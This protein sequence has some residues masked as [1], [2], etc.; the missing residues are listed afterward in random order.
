MKQFL[1][2][3]SNLCLTGLILLTCLIL[4]RGFFGEYVLA[5]V[6][7][8]YD[9]F[10][11]YVPAYQFFARMLKEG[12]S[13]YN[14]SYG[15]GNNVFI[16]ISWIADPFSA[17][18]VIFG[19]L[20]G[21]EKIPQFLV[22]NQ[23]LKILCAG[24]ICKHYLKSHGISEKSSVLASYCFAFSGYMLT[25]GQ[26]Y[27]FAVY[28]S[29]FL[30]LLLS[31][32]HTIEKPEKAYQVL[33][34]A[35]FTALRSPY[36]AYMT[37][38]AGAVYAI[39]LSL[40]RK[41]TFA[42]AVKK[43]ILLGVTMASGLLMA[44]FC[45][46]PQAE[47]ILNSYRVAGNEFSMQRILEF[48]KPASL[49]TLVTAFL[50]LF[51]NHLQGTANSW[52]GVEQHFEAFPYFFSAVFVLF[53]VQF[54]VTEF[55]KK[56]RNEKK[57]KLLWCVFL[58]GFFYS[59]L[60]HF[61]PELFNLFVQ[62][63]YRF[64]YIFLP[65]FAWIMAKSLDQIM[66]QGIFS[67]KANVLTVGIAI[68]LLLMIEDKFCEK[69]EVIQKMLLLAIVT[70]LLGA[71]LL[72]LLA[73]CSKKEIAYGNGKKF[74][75][76]YVCLF[77]VIAGNL[78]M[79]NDCTLYEGRF[80]ATG[81]MYDAMEDS[82][83]HEAVLTADAREGD[84]FYRME[85]DAHIGNYADAM[86]ALQSGIRSLSIYDT[87][88]DSGMGEFLTKIY[89]NTL[90]KQQIY[91]LN[92]YNPTGDLVTAST[93]G[94]KYLYSQTDLQ[95]EGWKLIESYPD[96][97][98]YENMQIETA[99]L[100]YQ[101]YT[102]EEQAD[103]QTTAERQLG[104]TQRVI[105]ADVPENIEK[106]AEKRD[107]TRT[108]EE[109]ESIRT[110]EIWGQNLKVETELV[111]NG[112]SISAEASKNAVLYIPI[113]LEGIDRTQEQVQISIICDTDVIRRILSENSDGR[114]KVVN[115]ELYECGLEEK[116]KITYTYSVPGDT[117]TLIFEIEEE[118]TEV[119]IEC[120]SLKTAKIEYTGN[121]IRLNNPGNGGTVSGTVNVDENSIL[122]LP[123]P[124]DTGWTATMDG[125]D[126]KV[127]K[128][129]YGFCAL[130]I[131]EGMHEVELVY[132]A[133]AFQ[134][135]RG[136]SLLMTAAVFGVFIA[137]NVKKSNKSRKIT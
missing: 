109:S 68:F 91:Y 81:E 17:L 59:V 97:K 103:Q 73:R 132:T 38:L 49:E 50:R 21:I 107:T 29:Y 52:Q 116:G 120:M 19:A 67:R 104:L 34:V 22:Y 124:Y 127:Y 82:S 23:I 130:L 26:H 134:W 125:K 25:A 69:D 11:Q 14:F 136:I 55:Q 43:I 98:L 53:A 20:F 79:E 77:V 92:G 100:L 46:L 41:D 31:V 72:E 117:K 106:Y 88:C 118:C 18:N 27:F 54:F 110:Q 33:V 111:E 62:P 133:R 71:V 58:A 131:D 16:A 64:V 28:P 10:H 84:S 45:F 36:S 129:N 96:A 61:V 65:A 8:G 90:Y 123:I 119:Q 70:L 4:Y 15:L 115:C 87:R 128:A 7:H 44:M 126:V 135:G 95:E 57:H 75:M 78:L 37:L 9:T 83:F 66:Y 12:E 35:F 60:F 39:C 47:K 13:I 122:Y 108:R 3:H 105:L 99:G 63:Q 2:K 114:Q 80:M 76:M 121:E 137:V 42:E 74:Q 30:L 85:T 6:D 89:G 51:S 5:Y 112:I 93:M 32:D 86:F 48:L 1:K 101:A 24:L 94:L 102:T 56:D 40:Y 113:H